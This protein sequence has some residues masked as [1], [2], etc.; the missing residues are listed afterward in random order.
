MGYRLERQKPF[1]RSLKAFISEG[2]AYGAIRIPKDASRLCLL[3]D[4]QTI[5]GYPKMGLCGRESAAAFLRNK[6]KP[7]DI[8]QFTRFT[9][10][11]PSRTSHLQM[12]RLAQW[13]LANK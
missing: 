13:R 9:W 7:G 5:D 12:A 6:K 1:T 10:I 11:K 3:R 8:I 4:R 2:I